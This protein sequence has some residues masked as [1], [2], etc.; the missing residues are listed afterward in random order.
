MRA[1]RQWSAV[2]IALVVLGGCT[3]QYKPKAAD[4][5]PFHGDLGAAGPV[6]V[7][8][9]AVPDSAQSRM[10]LVTHTVVVDHGQASAMVVDRLVALLEAQGATVDPTAANALEIEVVHV[11]MSPGNP[12]RCIIDVTLHP[13]NRPPRGI[14]VRDESWN[15]QTACN[16]ALARAAQ[17][18]LE[19][20]SAR[21]LLLGTEPSRRVEEP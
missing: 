7:R 20:S 9:R 4:L 15:Y 16:R 8:A 3:I 17:R 19:D 14:Q 10:A 1:P 5:E 12:M 18:I 2:L 13:T 21:A 11:A 6:A